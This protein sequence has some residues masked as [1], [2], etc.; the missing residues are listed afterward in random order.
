MRFDARICLI[1]IAATSCLEPS[2][3]ASSLSVQTGSAA[4][5]T[6]ADAYDLRAGP[7]GYTA[8]IGFVF[9]NRRQTPV[10]VANC[11]GD[12]PP[13]L[14]RFRNGE[15]VRAW[16]PVVRLCLSPSIVIEAGK[17]YQGELDLFAGYPDGNTYPKFKTAPIPG[18]YRLVWDFLLSSHDSRDYPYDPL[19][20]DE[21]VSNSFTL[22]TR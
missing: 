18:V 17:K 21:R 16:T 10:Y 20:L 13:G 11:G 1:L 22:T 7:I 3:P 12:A 15:W 14:E 9:T 8:T 2:A 5:Q 19:P 4:I 6:D